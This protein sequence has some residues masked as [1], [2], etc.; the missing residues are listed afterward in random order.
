MFGQ[1]LRFGFV[2]YD[3]NFFVYENPTVVD[4]LTVDGVVRTMTKI[5]ETFYYP[6]TVL[7]FMLDSTL[8]DMNPHGFH[9]TNVILH[10]ASVLLLFLALWRMTRSLWKSSFVAALFAIH[11]LQAEAVAWITAR[12]DLLSGC[13]F[14]LTLHAYISYVRRPFSLWRYSLLLLLFLAGL[15]SKPM[16][17]TL[18][19]V[20]LLLDFWPLGRWKEDKGQ[21]TEI[22]GQKSN[23]AHSSR[24][25]PKASGLRPFRLLV[26]EK[27][28]LLFIA[29]PFC[30][31]PFFAN[32][33]EET[34]SFSA[35][36]NLL[37][38]MGNAAVSY[39]AYM[40]QMVFPFD[41][42]VPYLDRNFSAWNLGLSTALVAGL[43]LL[44]IFFRKQKPYILIGGLWYTGMLLPVSGVLRF[45]GTTR[46]DRFVYLP[47]I[48][49]FLVVVW[50][51]ADI[52]VRK[53]CQR[54]AFSVGILIL[55]AFAWFAH[56]QTAHWQNT[57]SLWKNT[58]E[59]TSENYIAHHNLALRLAKQG[60][61]EE[62]VSHYEKAIQ[63]SPTYETAHLNLGN[64]LHRQN[65]DKEAAQ[66]YQKL[67]QLNSEHSKANNN[68]AWVLST[69][70]DAT[71]RNGERAVALAQ[72]ANRLTGGTNTSFLDTL[73]V[74]YA[75]AGR[76]PEAAAT[77]RQAIKRLDPSKNTTRIEK[78]RARLRLY[79]QSLPCRE[80]D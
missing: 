32:C 62:A 18:P 47:L 14:M 50:W 60:A 12:K 68:L 73:A 3:D 69:S 67:L 46:A 52:C 16:L 26:L 66:C 25:K 2:D 78:L 55:A 4:G 77:A 56:A 51:A 39:V 71:L 38:R 54:E 65:K 37:W 20:F 29:S 61:L 45:L 43:L 13:F 64:V 11:P 42:A 79:E 49:L 21:R 30:V 33:A 72:K 75:E 10:T 19:F 6:F 5:D 9:L 59:R 74:A 48:G 27:I 28:P 1:T 80:T 22:R 36:P 35:Q 76:Y 17:V 24:Q 7:S 57:F 70:S 34:L 53:R 31:I 58:L 40:R 63:I 23:V 41:L 15:F 44:G 8:H